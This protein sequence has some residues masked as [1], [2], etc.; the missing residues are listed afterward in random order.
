MLL[1]YQDFDGINRAMAEEENVASVAL[2]PVE[3]LAIL[4][5]REAYIE[6]VA[7]AAAAE[8]PGYPR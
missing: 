4:N 7:R 5:L 8:T 3:N 1:H 6:F 2:T